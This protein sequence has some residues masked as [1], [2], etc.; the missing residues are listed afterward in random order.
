MLSNS[1]EFQKSK[2]TFTMLTFRH[3][4]LTCGWRRSPR[5]KQSKRQEGQKPDWRY[6]EDGDDKGK[7]HTTGHSC[8]NTTSHGA[9]NHTLR[10]NEITV[11]YCAAQRASWE[12]TGPLSGRTSLQRGNANEARSK[13]ASMS[14]DAHEPRTTSHEPRAIAGTSKLT[15]KNHTRESGYGRSLRD[16]LGT[17]LLKGP[18]GVH[19]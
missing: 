16:L 13:N 1:V 8:R 15:A 17:Q 3:A 4:L 10:D 2:K 14:L 9:A 11:A 12:L 18:L 5:G 19:P 7:L 6:C